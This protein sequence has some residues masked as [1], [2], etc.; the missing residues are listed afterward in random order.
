MWRFPGVFRQFSNLLRTNIVELILM[1]EKTKPLLVNNWKFTIGA[2]ILSY[3]QEIYSY[4]YSYFDREHRTLRDISE[5]YQKSLKNMCSRSHQVSFE[6]KRLDCTWTAGRMNI[7]IF[8]ANNTIQSVVYH[9]LKGTCI[10]TL[11][12]L[13]KNVTGSRRC[14]W[15]QHGM[16]SLSVC[17]Y[18]QR[19]CEMTQ[20]MIILKLDYAPSIER[21]ICGLY[22]NYCNL[23]S[24]ASR[25]LT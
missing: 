10:L 3:I 2:D 1:D 17:P 11:C 18:D 21:L 15:A 6:T 16:Q 8:Y 19:L 7:M 4:H 13:K 14:F 25:L 20:V 24:V 5:L 12:R 23:I 22:N 9:R